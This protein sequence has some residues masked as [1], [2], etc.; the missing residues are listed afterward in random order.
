[1]FTL[2]SGRQASVMH[3]DQYVFDRNV[4]ELA[5]RRWV[6]LPELASVGLGLKQTWG[7]LKVIET[8]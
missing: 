8:A 6:F 4:P 7:V 5:H 3:I 1:M 2:N